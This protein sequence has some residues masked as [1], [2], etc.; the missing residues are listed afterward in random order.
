MRY[1]LI[2]CLL[3]MCIGFLP[4]L[5]APVK[6][7][8]VAAQYAGMSLVLETYNNFI[9]NRVRPLQVLKVDQKGRFEVDVD[10]EE[11][12]QVFM[13]LGRF[14]AHLFVEPGVDYQVVLPPFEPR[15]DGE[16]FNP[17]YQPEDILLGIVNQASK[18][19]NQALNGLDE[20]Y[21]MLYNKHAIDLVRR[22]YIRLGD[23]M[24]ASLDSLQDSFSHPFYLD[25][26]QYR[27]AVFY[28]LPRNR[29]MT[30]VTRTFFANRPVLFNNP[31]YWDALRSIYN[32]YIDNY[33][34]SSKGKSL[35][36][37]LH[38]SNRFDSISSAMGA[39][40][41][42]HNG[43]FREILLLKYL[44]DGFYSGKITAGRA[45]L[46]L[47]DAVETACSPRIRSIAVD[48]VA[49]I[50]HLKTGTPAPEFVLR[51][52]KGK[53]VALSD[54]RGKFVYLAFMHTQNFACLKDI[55]A[56]D[57]IYDRFKKDLVVL[58]VVTNENQDEAEAYFKINKVAW[59]ILSFASGQKII[60]DYNISALPTYFLINPDGDMVLSP[61][62]SPD[63]SFNK[64]F[65]DV[66]QAYRV[67][68]IRKDRPKEKSIYDL[69]R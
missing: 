4:A 5:S 65:M 59:P 26:L 33:M 43:P 27:K 68:Q 47:V 64:V 19:L 62:P 16:R 48:L 40:T 46:L 8:G 29:Q 36:S 17:F 49:R 31:A 61:A 66:F 45:T 54:Y 38:A 34:R 12:T 10:V 30:A 20:Q 37:A 55:P 7:H 14:R 18:N 57:A 63:E 69:F 25:Y 22:Q 9:S 23:E 52:Y 53:E 35:A 11:V 67:Q 44:Y 50:N 42:F 58:G 6:I 41:L 56:L 21:Q 15:P 13:E 32:G 2:H 60:F 28:A 24:M 1:R 39:D 3:F 51:N